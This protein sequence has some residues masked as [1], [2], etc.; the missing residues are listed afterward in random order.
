MFSIKNNQP[1]ISSENHEID[2]CTKVNIS[3]L[4]LHQTP[5]REKKKTEGQKS[6]SQPLVLFWLRFLNEVRTFFE[7][8]PDSDFIA[9]RPLS[10]RNSERR[11]ARVQIIPK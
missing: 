7:E 9:P 8:N 5:I 11:K 4:I 6:T 3:T 1:S 2:L 10:A